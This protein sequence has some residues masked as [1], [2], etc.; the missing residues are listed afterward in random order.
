[1][2]LECWCGAKCAG[3]FLAHH[4]H[5]PCCVHH[6]G[7]PSPLPHPSLTLACLDPCSGVP[8]AHLGA[9]FMGNSASVPVLVG[10]AVDQAKA[11]RDLVGTVSERI[12]SDKEFFDSIRVASS[13]VRATFADLGVA[14]WYTGGAAADEEYFLPPARLH[15]LQTSVHR[16][17]LAPAAGILEPGGK[18]ATVAHLVEA[19]ASSMPVLPCFAAVHAKRMDILWHLFARAVGD[20]DGGDD[21]ET[22]G[23]LR[24]GSRIVRGPDWRWVLGGARSAPRH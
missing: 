20:V 8:Q 4:L 14:D 15:E 18:T 11:S 9:A 5:H 3:L 19:L 24:V 22:A 7:V 1:M 13:N 2:H 23:K 10:H 12:F 6:T 21:A 17:S 16:A